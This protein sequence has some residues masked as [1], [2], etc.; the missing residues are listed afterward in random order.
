MRGP[1]YA[2]SMARFHLRPRDPRTHEFARL[3]L[4]PLRLT[5][6]TRSFLVHDLAHYAAEAEAGLLGGF[7]GLTAAGADPRALVAFDGAGGELAVAEALSAPLQSL[8]HGRM[9]PGLYEALAAAHVPAAAGFAERALER[10]R[11]VMGA[12]RATPFGG[13]LELE[14]PP[15]APRVVG[16]R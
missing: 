12:W 16:R 8:W 15:T 13:A 3:D 14:W 2:L 5:L 11:T 10:M 9:E 6:D 7:W 1:N 4:P